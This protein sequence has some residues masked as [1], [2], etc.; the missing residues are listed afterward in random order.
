MKWEQKEE[1]IVKRFALG[2]MIV[3][4]YKIPSSPMPM[5]NPC[6]YCTRNCVAKENYKCD[7]FRVM[8]LKAWD[9][10]VAFLRKCAG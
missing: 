6:L 1:R 3:D 5:S 9:E 4:D 2:G 8:F 10:T 7:M